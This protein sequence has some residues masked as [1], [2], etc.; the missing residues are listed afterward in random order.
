MIRHFKIHTSIPSPIVIPHFPL[1][2]YFVQFSKLA[3][4][5]TSTLSCYINFMKSNRVP[6][7][8]APS[9]NLTLLTYSNIF[10]TYYHSDMDVFRFSFLSPQSS[11]I[12]FLIFL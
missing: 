7:P 6:F 11:T 1:K 4:P 3:L 2:G 12:I 8:P 10:I 5:I 9:E